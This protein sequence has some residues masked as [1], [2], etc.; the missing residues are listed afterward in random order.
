MEVF[1]ISGLIVGIDGG[2]TS[3]DFILCDFGG[4]VKHRVV[5]GPSNPNDI[6]F[7]KSCEVLKNGLSEL[8]GQWGGL[9][10]RIDGLFAGL[11]GGTVGKNKERFRIFFETLLPNSR[12]ENG[13]DAENAIALGLEEKDGITLISGT[14][15]VAFVQKG[16]SIKR[17]GGW[18]YLFDWAGSGYNL[19]RDAICAA[20]WEFDGMG[21]S[22]L[23]TKMLETAMGMPVHEALPDF[24][25]KGKRYI[26]SFAPI[27]FSAYEQ[28]DLV[29][30]E[31]INNTANHLSELLLTAYKH[32]DGSSTTVVLVGGIFKRGDI[33][34]PLLKN[35]IN[36]NLDFI[37]PVFP[38]IFGAI[39]KASRVAGIETDALFKNNF[40]RTAKE[41][42][43]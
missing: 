18:G 19:G 25:R 9:N 15:S 10:A 11:S 32:L 14:G 36:M 28:H 21:P 31:I 6:G 12:C 2:G 22:T 43:K 7:E 34:L 26:A 3:T 4:N 27:V 41:E 42:C 16:G 35:K 17:I 29:A 1:K 38:P 30:V 5:L 39:W 24:Y 37:A 33:I 40:R 20:L 8:L 23:L 13:S